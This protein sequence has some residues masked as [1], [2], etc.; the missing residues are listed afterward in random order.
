MFATHCRCHRLN[1]FTAHKVG[2]FFFYYHLGNPHHNSPGFFHSHDHHPSP[3]CPVTQLLAV[4]LLAT[5]QPFLWYPVVT[6]IAS[7]LDKSSGLCLVEGAGSGGK[8]TGSSPA[9]LTAETAV[10]GFLG[11]EEGRWQPCRVALRSE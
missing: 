3:P 1:A 6:F 9:S 10:L 11:V 5:P 4:S 7:H 2:F 8:Q